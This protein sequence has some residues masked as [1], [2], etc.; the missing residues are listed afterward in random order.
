[1]KLEDL[2]V[3]QQQRLSDVVVG[4]VLSSSSSVGRNSRSY[5]HTL[6]NK[7]RE[8]ND[9][10]A[11]AVDRYSRSRATRPKHS[12]GGVSSDF[13]AEHND[14]QVQYTFI[15]VYKYIY[16]YIYSLYLF[17]C[18]SLNLFVYIHIQGVIIEHE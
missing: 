2:V 14:S 5:S 15:C 13:F 8:Y 12:S 9:M 6:R 10:V 3:L 11:D 17:P 4:G 16:I 1:M 7:D 18:L